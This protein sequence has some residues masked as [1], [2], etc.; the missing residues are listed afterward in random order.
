MRLCIDLDNTICENKKEGQSYEDVLPKENAVSVL[1]DFRNSGHY[2][3]I[4]TARHMKT[5]GGN[6]GKITAIQGPI[7]FSW[8]K[9]HNV[10]Y[11]EIVFGKPN[12][13]YFIDDKAIPFTS[14]SNLQQIIS[15]DS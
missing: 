8:L 5:C 10:P 9:K 14:W 2:I 13:D 12:A 1:N 6:V 4:Y 15:N 11:D 3:I 7:L